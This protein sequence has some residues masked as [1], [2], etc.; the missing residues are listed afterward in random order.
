[1]VVHVVRDVRDDARGG[2]EGGVRGGVRGGALATPP[3]PGRGAS[4]PSPHTAVR[5]RLPHTAVSAHPPIALLRH[6]ACRTVNVHNRCQS[7]NVGVPVSSGGPAPTSVLT[8]VPLPASVEVPTRP[9]LR[10][11]HNIPPTQDTNIVVP[12]NKI[13][14]FLA[15]AKIHPKVCPRRFSI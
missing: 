13:N 6:L 7:G 3:W 12:R 14:I 2:G 5:R 10:P 4:P 9:I 11:Y 15:S 8:T 1:M